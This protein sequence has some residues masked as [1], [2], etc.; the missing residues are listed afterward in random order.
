MTNTNPNAT[1]REILYAEGAQVW[2]V[3]SQAAASG[4]V[5]VMAGKNAG[6]VAVSEEEKPVGYPT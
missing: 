1:T 3:T 4:A 2:P 6:G 5:R